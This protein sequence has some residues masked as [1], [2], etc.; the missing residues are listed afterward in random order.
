MNI[1]KGKCKKSRGSTRLVAGG[2]STQGASQAADGRMVENSSH[3][4]M[5]EISSQQRLDVFI[6]ALDSLIWS[7]Y[8]ASI[9]HCISSIFYCFD[10]PERRL[11][12]PVSSH[13][14]LSGYIF[15]SPYPYSF[16]VHT[17]GSEISALYIQSIRHAV[18]FQ[19]MSIHLS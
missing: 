6:V 12:L 14:A 4:A 3:P 16:L 8:N 15:T 2:S 13:L 19:N 17:D 18:C 5:N 7:K 1:Q 10:R 9:F 11:N